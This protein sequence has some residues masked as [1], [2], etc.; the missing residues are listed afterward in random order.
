MTQ[1]LQHQP[2]LYL[3]MA[4]IH[5]QQQQ[6]EYYYPPYPDPQ[7][8]VYEQQQQQALMSPY[9]DSA[10]SHSH[11]HQH[12]HHTQ[13]QGI[14]PVMPYAQDY[15]Q[16]YAAPDPQMY[17]TQQFWGH[18]QVPIV[19]P[20]TGS[21]QQQQDMVSATNGDSLSHHHHHPQIFRQI[22]T[23][24]TSRAEGAGHSHLAWQTS[25]R[26][27]EPTAMDM[28]MMVDGGMIGMDGLPVAMEDPSGSGGTTTAGTSTTAGA[29]ATPPAYHL[30]PA[31]AA[32]TP[33]AYPPPPARHRRAAS[34]E[35]APQ[36]MLH[37]YHR[38]G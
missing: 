31:A 7:Q 32:A 1:P 20:H 8:Q 33:A 22:Q 21:T 4:A 35:G 16:F 10:H 18:A 11:H 25:P 29:S 23:A 9:P 19:P 36:G 24:T 15:Q 27:Y 28:L 37:P 14:S 17:N 12:T 13:Q 30:A 26:S 3:D 5:H 6:Q 38:A 34:S 2:Q